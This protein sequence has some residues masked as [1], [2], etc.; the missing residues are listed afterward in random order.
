MYQQCLIQYAKYGDYM[1][2]E[3][4]FAG[5]DLRIAQLFLFYIVFCLTTGQLSHKHQ[6][7]GTDFARAMAIVFL[8][9]EMEQM[10][11]YQ[12]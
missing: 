12:Q 1:P 11:Y 6:N 2:I 9:N 8:M 10:I 3:Q 5:Y 4:A 7:K